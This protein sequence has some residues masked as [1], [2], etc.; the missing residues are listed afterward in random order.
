MSGNNGIF[1]DLIVNDK[2]FLNE[3]SVGGRSY[4]SKSNGPGV[5]P[6]IKGEYHVFAEAQNK[7][8]EWN[9]IQGAIDQAL[10]DGY[11]PA[12]RTYAHVIIHHSDTPYTGDINDEIHVP[13]SIHLHGSN[14]SGIH[15]RPQIAATLVFS[16]TGSAFDTDFKNLIWNH[17]N[18]QLIQPGPTKGCIRYI[19]DLTANFYVLTFMDILL[20]SSQTTSTVPLCIFGNFAVIVI[21]RAFIISSNPRETIRAKDA[22]TIDF[23]NS[24]F[25]GYR[26]IVSEGIGLAVPGTSLY[27]RNCNFA[28]E[29]AFTSGLDAEVVIFEILSEGTLVNWIIHND[30]HYFS[31]GNSNI[32]IFKASNSVVNVWNVLTNNSYWYNPGTGTNYL[33]D[34]PNTVVISGNNSIVPGSISAVNTVI[35]PAASI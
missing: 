26:F 2:T 23:I 5:L 34:A 33:Y 31:P 24:I 32:T 30:F 35:N 29:T 28:V 1:Y 3:L 10:N 16:N 12:S 4:H 15:G 18:F 6:Y 19:A 22:T 25:V 11:T 9:T 17:S 20:Y 27:M 21:D 14:G 8:N 7:G 13:S